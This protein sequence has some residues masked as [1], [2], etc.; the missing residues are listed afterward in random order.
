V[1]ASATALS[2][3]NFAEESVTDRIGTPVLFALEG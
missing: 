2:R 3:I 1:T